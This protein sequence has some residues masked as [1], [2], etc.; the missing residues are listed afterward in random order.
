MRALTRF[1][2]CLPVLLPAP[3][4]FGEDDAT[5]KAL[6]ENAALKYYQA[7]ISMPKLDELEERALGEWKTV[8]LSPAVIQ[9]IKKVETSLKFVDQGARIERCEWGLNLEEGPAALMPYL[10]QARKLAR[11]VCLRSRYRF[12]KGESAGAVADVADALALARH[13]GSDGTLIAL[14]VGYAIEQMVTDLLSDNLYKLDGDHLKLLAARIEA[15]PPP[16]TVRDAVLKER[17]VFVGWMMR[18]LDAAGDQ[19][20]AAFQQMGMGNKWALAIASGGTVDG[21]KKLVEQVDDYYVELAEVLALPLDQFEKRKN[22]LEEKLKTANPL[23]KAVAPALQRIRYNE[24]RHQVK[25][26][27][28]R[29]AIG[30]LRE[31]PDLVKTSRNP[32]DGEPFEIVQ[33]EDGFDLLARNEIE[34]KQVSLRISQPAM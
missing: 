9:L 8:S 33:H 5:G 10:A 31:G 25:I 15:L 30:V 13:S 17:E 16:G 34:G 2:L 14:L 23:V 19:A 21:L 7:L 27:L 32:V 3:R 1:A 22:A 24:A 6:A 12:G 11:I 18:K 20:L 26:A 29:L 28:L 4:A